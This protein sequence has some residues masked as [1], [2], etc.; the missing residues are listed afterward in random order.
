M[1]ALLI[2]E[3]AGRA[4]VST[5][6]IRYYES[7]GLLEAPA[8]SASGYRRYPVRAVDTVRFIKKAQTLGFSLDE[9]GEILKLSRSGQAP[10]SHVASLGRQHLAAVDDRI[11][12]LQ[13]FRDQLSAE[14]ARW[15]GQATQDAG[16]CGGLCQLIAEAPDVTEVPLHLERSP[17]DVRA[18]G[19]R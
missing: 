15:D 16:A 11:Q 3:L 10:C 7:L 12:Q 1:G 13:A 8:R 2:G 19:P 5:P 9:V 14:L 18:R 4:G 6:T 17:R